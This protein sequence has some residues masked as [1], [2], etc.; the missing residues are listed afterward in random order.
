[1]TLCERRIP[2]DVHAS[3]AELPELADFLGTF[4]VRFRRPE[5]AEALAHYMTGLLTELP[6][7]NGDILA[8][9]VP[10]TSEQRLQEF[11]TNMP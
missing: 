8:Q 1:M 5:G 4:H 6:A 7:K 3:P 11:L 2:L 9:A 10:A